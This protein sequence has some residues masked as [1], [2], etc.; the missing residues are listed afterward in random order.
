MRD[1]GH[2][3]RPSYASNQPPL[4]SDLYEFNLVS[5]G[6]AASGTGEMSLRAY[7]KGR[8]ALRQVRD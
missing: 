1:G 8:S 3:R 5:A 2:R 6:A 4:P 7:Q